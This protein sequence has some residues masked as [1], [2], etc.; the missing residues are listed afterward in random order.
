[1]QSYVLEFMSVRIFEQDLL[2]AIRKETECS[3]HA[4]YGMFVLIIMSH[5]SEDCVY[6]TDGKKL[7]MGKVWPLLAPDSFKAMTGKPKLVFLQACS[8]GIY[9]CFFL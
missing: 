9:M 7:F 8:G 2:A 5:G 3:D 1:M 4:N 6:G